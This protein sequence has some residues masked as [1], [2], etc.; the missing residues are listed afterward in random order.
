M[1]SGERSGPVVA[2][3]P[4]GGVGRRFNQLQPKQFS[5]L[6]Q[7]PVLAHTLSQFEQTASVD[8]VILVVPEG[9][10]DF[11]RSEILERFGFQK[12]VRVITGGE[13]RQDS[14]YNGFL[15]LE[16]D[17]ELVLIHDAVRPLVRVKTIEEVIQAARE[18]GAAIAAV[19]VRDTLKLVEGETIVQT[20]D[21]S[22]L[23]QAQTPQVFDRLWLAEAL[24]TAREN[25]FIATDEAALIERLGRSVRIVAGAVDNIKITLPEDFILA[26]SL[27]EYDHKGRD[28]RIGI[29]YDVHAFISGRKL[30]L[31]GVEVPHEQGLAGHSDADVIVHALCDAMLGAAGLPDI[32]VN[33]PDKDSQWAGM[34]GRAMLG[35][36]AHKV[37]AAGFDLVNADLTLIAERPRIRD[38]VPEMIQIM[39]EALSTEPDRLNVKGTT[40][41]GLGA[42]GRQEGL[43]AWAVVLL[44][45][46][47][48][49]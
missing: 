31:G 10:E 9:Q 33:F 14:V 29:G 40:T 42:I 26:E 5:D 15:A 1:N 36:V 45:R 27:L 44:S 8:R 38:H 6:G 20:L 13:R 35:Q 22:Q 3:I 12:V 23:W 24:S 32:G 39:A 49:R 30:M 16:D 47:R 2:I 25:G 43:A 34:E 41:E 48:C 7:W 37:R 17:I 4:A 11:V 21:R 18:T 28:M 19:P 46:K